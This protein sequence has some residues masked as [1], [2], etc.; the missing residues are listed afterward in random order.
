[1]IALLACPFCNVDGMLSRDFILIVFGAAIV[2]FVCLLFWSI[3]RGHFKNVEK[4]K[5]RILELDEKT[6]V[7]L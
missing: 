1:M 4:P 3:G 2:G 7:R 6:K 5:Y